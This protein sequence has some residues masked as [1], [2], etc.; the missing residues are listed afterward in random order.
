MEPTHPTLVADAHLPP[1]AGVQS[2]RFIGRLNFATLICR[3]AR[4]DC[5][6]RLNFSEPEAKERIKHP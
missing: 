4:K 1:G 6:T 2:T 3:R 5:G